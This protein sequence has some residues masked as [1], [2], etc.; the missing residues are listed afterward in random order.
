MAAV[1]IESVIKKGVELALNEPIMNGKSVMQWAE[2]GIHSQE[3]K[4]FVRVFNST[5]TSRPTIISYFILY[6]LLQRQ[7]RPV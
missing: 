1:D 3:Q 5:W 4:I 6:S 2:I 7:R